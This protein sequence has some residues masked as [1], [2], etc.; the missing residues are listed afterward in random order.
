MLNPSQSDGQ[1]ALFPDLTVTTPKKEMFQWEIRVR[2]QNYVVNGTT[3][4]QA[5]AEVGRAMGSLGQPETCYRHVLRYKPVV[6]SKTPV[7]FL[8]QQ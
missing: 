5:L 2:D 1:N 8:E 7:R 3:K 4:R 6:L